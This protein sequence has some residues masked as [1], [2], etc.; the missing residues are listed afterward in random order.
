MSKPKNH[1]HDYDHPDAEPANEVMPGP[2][3]G[4]QSPSTYETSRT[5][6]GPTP[7]PLV[8]PP[9][10]HDAKREPHPIEAALTSADEAIRKAQ[11]G[12]EGSGIKALLAIVAAQIGVKLT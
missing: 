11:G 8:E 2:D 3:Q 4:D 5:Y 1:D 6:P 9:P 12:P 7:S 10:D